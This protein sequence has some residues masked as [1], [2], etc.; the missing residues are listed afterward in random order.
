MDIHQ[1]SNTKIRVFSSQE[2]GP[3]YIYLSGEHQKEETEE[4]YQ[5]L[6]VNIKEPFSFYEWL[7]DDW[8]R[9]LTPWKVVSCL[10]GRDFSGEGQNLLK[11]IEE[12]IRTELRSAGTS[13]PVYLAGYSLAG[14]FSM[15]ALYE[16]DLLDGVVC[17]SGS[18]WYPGWIEYIRNREFHRPVTIYLS[19][20]NKEEFT[21]HPIMKKVGDATREQ[22]QCLLADPMVREITLEWKEGGHFHN[23]LER[24]AAGMIWISKK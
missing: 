15:W 6:L 14:L 22:Y 4:L 10:K 17:G 8:D 21:R 7:V 20:G 19:L 11:E 5:K 12:Y 18:L 23:V 16:S 1:T 13:R 24:I 9:M 3:V 2:T